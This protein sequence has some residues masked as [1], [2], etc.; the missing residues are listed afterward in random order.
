MRQSI[1]N[2]LS[3]DM[4]DWFHAELIRSHV[5]T[6]RPERR[7]EW[8]VEPFLMLLRRYQA[9]ATFFVVGDV[10]RHHPTLVRRIYEEGHEIGCHGWSHRPLWSLDAERFDEELQEFDREVA[11]IL[12]PEQVVGFRAPTFSLDERTGWA[13]DVLRRRGFLYDSSI[14]PMRNYLYGVSDAPPQPY[15]PTPQ[16]LTMDHHDA[17]LIEFPMTTFRLASMRI[18]VSGGFYLRAIP[19]PLLKLLLGGVNAQGY[20]FVIYVHP[21]EADG[22][23]PRVRDLSWAN[24]LV[25]Y[26]S[27][28]SVLYKLE[29]LLKRFHFAPLRD[30]LELRGGRT[31]PE[32]GGSS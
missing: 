25:T 13:L 5:R 15:R 20:P 31:L 1:K 32:R 3:I 19:Q 9:R 10:L 16:E 7:V 26:Y 2:A 8:A 28:R 30:V 22:Q 17:Q 12:P 29:D 27:S 6:A 21:W 24:R 14:F 23:T 11:S 4:E 18:P